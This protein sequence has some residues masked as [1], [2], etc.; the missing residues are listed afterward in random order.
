MLSEAALGW[1]QQKHEIMKLENVRTLGPNSL[2]SEPHNHSGFAGFLL[3]LPLGESLHTVPAP[4]KPLAT[5]LARVPG[6][7]W[8]F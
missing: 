7:Q 6:S 3:M 5:C 8:S 2:S 4:T 1:L